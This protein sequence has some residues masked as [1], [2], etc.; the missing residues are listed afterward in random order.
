MAKI[1]SYFCR[2]LLIMEK[3]FKHY[4]TLMFLAVAWGSLI[5]L[6]KDLVAY[7]YMQVASLRLFIAFFSLL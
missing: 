7:D 1:C 6:Q 2:Q 5:L 3:S 4:I